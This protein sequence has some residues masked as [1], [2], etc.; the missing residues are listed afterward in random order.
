MNVLL[1]GK[2]LRDSRAELAYGSGFVEWYAEEAK[3]TYGDVIP[4]ASA[5]KRVVVVKEP[6]GVAAMITPVRELIIFNYL[7]AYIW[8]SYTIFFVNIYK[9][10]NCYTLL[11]YL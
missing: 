11:L 6:V 9:L 4:S 3:R 5:N 10:R 8:I 1:Q 2:P 7:H